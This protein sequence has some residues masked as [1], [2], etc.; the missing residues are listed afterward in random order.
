LGAGA[1]VRGL[2]EFFLGCAV[3]LVVG[4]TVSQWFTGYSGSLV[5]AAALVIA[6]A[7]M[8]DTGFVIALACAPLLLSLCGDNVT[9]R[10]LGCKPLHYLG[11]ISY[12]VYLGHF[13]FSSLAYRLISPAWMAQ[14]PSHAVVGVAVLTVVIIVASSI[15]FY[16]IER[17]ARRWLGGR[18]N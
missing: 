15:T 14:S 4:G 5:A 2:T 10:V 13:L 16:M 11:E 8:P 3:A 17:P 6:Y 9:S 12:S 7:L 18:S 1:I